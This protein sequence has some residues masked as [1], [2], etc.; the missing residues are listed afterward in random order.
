MAG[1]KKH[2]DSFS[3]ATIRK[4]DARPRFG[5]GPR[6]P[7]SRPHE[8]CRCTVDPTKQTEL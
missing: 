2:G 4:V 6:K 8:D 1:L 7:S 3:T 5:H